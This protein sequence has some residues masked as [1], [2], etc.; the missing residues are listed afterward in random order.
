MQTIPWHSILTFVYHV[1]T[2][3]TTGNN[4]EFENK[5]IGKSNKNLC[6]ECADLISGG[7]C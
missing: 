2:N 5:R 3:C 4:I 1:S 6:Q 7:R